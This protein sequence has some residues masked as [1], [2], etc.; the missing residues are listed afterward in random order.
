MA[1]RKEVTVTVTQTTGDLPVY[2]SSAR[3]DNDLV[4]NIFKFAVLGIAGYLVYLFLV[5]VLLPLLGGITLVL[6]AVAC[7]LVLYKTELFKVPEVRDTTR[8]ILDVMYEK[9]QREG[10]NSKRTQEQYYTFGCIACAVVLVLYLFGTITVGVFA[11]NPDYH[12]FPVNVFGAVA[13]LMLVQ[14]L[15][16][17]LSWTLQMFASKTLHFKTAVVSRYQRNLPWVTSVAVLV[18]LASLAGVNF[19]LIH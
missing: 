7:V 16:Q 2:R 3:S 18:Y 10:G 5:H 8:P 11:I 12:M 15:V 9:A 1:I 6:L 14:Q 17:T 4:R 19:G 13:V